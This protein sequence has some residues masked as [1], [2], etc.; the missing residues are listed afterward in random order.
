[1]PFSTSV[2]PLI[3]STSVYMCTRSRARVLQK[4]VTF[5]V[6][7]FP[8]FFSPQFSSKFEND[9]TH[10][11]LTSGKLHHLMTSFFFFDEHQEKMMSCEPMRMGACMWLLE[12]WMMDD[13]RP[14]SYITS[15]V[16]TIIYI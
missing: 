9:Q 4:S 2:F 8:F 1:L 12:K 11:K 5:C 13:S 7:I 6:K 16:F 14:S 3:L 10:Q 15:L